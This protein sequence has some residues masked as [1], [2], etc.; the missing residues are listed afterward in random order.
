MKTSLAICKKIF[1]LLL[2]L[3]AAAGKLWA[4]EASDFPQKPSLLLPVNDYANVLS[5]SEREQLTAKIRQYDKATSTTI[6]VVTIPS[7]GGYE[8]AQYATE[9]GNRWQIGRKGKNNGI[10]ILAAIEERKVNISV[11]RG[12]EGVLTDIKSGQIIRNEMVPAFKTGDY[13]E[14]FSK[15]TDA[16]IA[17]TKGEYTA[18]PDEEGDGDFSGGGLILMVVVIVILLRFFGGGGNGGGRYM[19]RRG[20]S[21]IPPVIFGGL[22]SGGGGWSSGGGGGGFG[23]GS[24]GGGGGGS[25]G[26]GGASGSW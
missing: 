4:Q 25:F 16:V 12:L 9:L 17:V 10:V 8:V 6:I 20:G 13:Y 7:I 5:G 26:G 3:S 23:G 11:G 1:L 15:A 2:F 19:S 18:D 14:G 21:W 22:G 24:F